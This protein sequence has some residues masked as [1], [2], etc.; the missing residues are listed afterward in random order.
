LHYKWSLSREFTGDEMQPKE[1][2]KPEQY[3]HGTQILVVDCPQGIFKPFS[4]KPTI[5]ANWMCLDGTLWVENIIPYMVYCHE[6]AQIN[7]GS[8]EL[9][10]LKDDLSGTIGESKTLFHATA[11]KWVKDLSSTGF[12]Y[13]GFVTDGCFIFKTK[14]NKLLMIWSSFGEKG[15][16]LG[17]LISESGSIFGP[18]KHI[19]K[20]IFKD[21]GGHGM[22]FKTFEGKL[23]ITLHQ[24][25]NSQKERPQ[26]YQLTDKG[27][28]LEISK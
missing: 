26:L 8:M 23:M 6:W 17:Q 9:I 27:D 20:L 21:N 14:N 7:E 25:N 12:K 4:N 15:Y 18:W 10:Q 24:P 19:D 11:A 3:Q 5:P 16:G 28:H 13:N 1:K 22:I 2:D